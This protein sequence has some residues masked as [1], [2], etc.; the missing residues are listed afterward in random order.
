MKRVFA[1]LVLLALALFVRPAAAHDVTGE[2]MLLDVGEDAIGVELQIPVTQVRSVA[3]DLFPGK[4]HDI[5][6]LEVAGV[7]PLVEAR[8]SATSKLGQRFATEVTSA[9]RAFVTGHDMVVVEARLVAP[10]GESA[11]WF[12]LRDDVILQQ[13]VTDSVYVFLRRDVRTGET[14]KPAFIGEMHYQQRTLTI[15]REVGSRGAIVTHAFRLGLHHI[16]EGADHILFLMMLLFAAPKLGS[17]AKI[18]TGF[19]LGHS[20][21]LIVSTLGGFTSGAWVERAI[22]LTILVTAAHAIRPIFPRKEPLIAAA[23]GLVHGLAFASALGPYGFDRPTLALSLL[24]FNL[25][26]EAMQLA[27]VLVTFPFLTMLAKRP[28]YRITAGAFGIVAALSLLAQHATWLDA[29]TRHG[30]AFV[31][32]LAVM[33]LVERISG[34][35]GLSGSALHAR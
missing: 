34:R 27:I 13:L 6:S 30:P 14:D 3:P 18:V 25:G 11:R 7:K 26:V 35:R 32:A 23:F 15:D 31:G 28:S 4:D 5:A 2:I 21:T 12:S 19:T 9:H 10:A 8:L 29:L 17:A 1:V 22:A 16:A 33:A 20:A 24:G